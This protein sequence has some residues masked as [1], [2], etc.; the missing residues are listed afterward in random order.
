M[1]SN[2]SRT[3]FGLLVVMVVG[4][5]AGCGSAGE[6]GAGGARGGSGAGRT[7]A[8]APLPVA[9][10]TVVAETV[11]AERQWHGRLEPLRVHSVQ[12][13]RA[14]RVAEVAVRDGDSVRAG[15]VLVRMEAP[16]L[17]ARRVVLAERLDFLAS[18]LERWRGLA[19]T[20]AA[21]PA[22]VAAAEL[23]VLEVRD[24]TGQIDSFTESYLVRA[25]ASGIVSGL[26]VNPGANATNGQ[27]LLQVADADVHGVR[28]IVPALET[29]FLESAA[30]LSLQ[31]DRGGTF[32]IERVV[33]TSDPHPAFARADLYVRGA[34]GHRAVTVRYRA[35]EELITVPWTAVASDGEV[36]WVAAIRAGEPERVERRRVV[37]GR[38]HAG[39]I[40]VLDGLAPGDRVIRFEPRSIPDGR[41]VLPRGAAPAGSS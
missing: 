14:G 36:H 12:A 37:L 30:S 38:A 34:T 18:E 19:A 8:E 23:R 4:L 3:S 41:A 6:G 1:L 13:P 29:S 27:V 31:D 32:P 24:E 16:D 20:G 39:G 25:P 22:E 2:V 35:E 21:G 15:A 5:L 28:L 17:D 7:G 40:E 11:V 33:L 9:A 26:A 10:W